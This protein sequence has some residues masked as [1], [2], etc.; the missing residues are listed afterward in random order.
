M[1][2]LTIAE[3]QKLIDDNILTEKDAKELQARNLVGTRIRQK[4]KPYVTNQDGKKVYP[5]LT[6]KE[7]GK[8][9]PDSEI[10]LKI[11]KEFVQLI[12]KYKENQ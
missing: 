6:F 10:M 7:H 1:G 4:E 12:N 5:A 2:R 8:G 9:N 11:R 3:V